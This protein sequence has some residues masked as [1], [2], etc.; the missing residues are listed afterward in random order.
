MREIHLHYQI[1]GAPKNITK[2]PP[3]KDE[4]TLKPPII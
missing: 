4:G 2:W 3:P 1:T